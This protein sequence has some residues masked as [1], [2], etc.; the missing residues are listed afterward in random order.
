MDADER[1]E[2]ALRAVDTY[3]RETD[4]CFDKVIERNDERDYL[5]DFLNWL[6][7]ASLEAVAES[8]RTLADQTDHESRAPE[9]T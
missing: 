9:M 6:D 5:L 2:L 7:D 1:K 3:I 8:F 4:A